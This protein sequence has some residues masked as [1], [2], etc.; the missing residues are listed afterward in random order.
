MAFAFS[1]PLWFSWTFIHVSVVVSELGRKGAEQIVINVR[2]EVK[3][4]YTFPKGEEYQR[5]VS[6][7]GLINVLSVNHTF[8]VKVRITGA[9]LTANR[10]TYLVDWRVVSRVAV[11]S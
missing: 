4:G 5:S 11:I 6:T 3:L 2:G 7:V 8:N 10:S 9:Q 1:S